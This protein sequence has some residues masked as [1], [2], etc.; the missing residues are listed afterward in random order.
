MSDFVQQALRAWHAMTAKQRFT[1]VFSF[2]LTAAA[3]GALVWW[4]RQ[5][6]W[7]T[8]YTGLDPKDAQAIVQELQA[9]KVPHRPADGYSAIEVPVENVESLRMELAAKNLPGSGRFGFLEMFGAE[10]IA[11]SDRTQRVKYQKA[12]EDELARTIESLDEVQGA[13]VHLVLPGDRVFVD[14]ADI[15]K[16]SVTLTLRRGVVPAPDQ[17]RSIVHI[18]S[19]AVE[20]LSPERV[21]VVDTMGHTLWEGDGATGGLITARQA[22]LKKGIEK[23]IDGKI[24]RVLEPI[25]GPAH[26]VVRTSAEMDFQKV[27]RRERTLDPDSGALI[28]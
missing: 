18:V 5:P 20:G 12:L 23:D 2:L 7:A 22:E 8:L 13:R 10:N 3:V 19:G 9:R 16:A 24:A 15:A 21:S 14:D 27:L 4:A 26:Y 25:V 17:V 1:L 6:S 28:S 11:Q